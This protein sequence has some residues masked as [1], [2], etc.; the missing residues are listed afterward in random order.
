MMFFLTT[1]IGED[2]DYWLLDDE[3][4][5]YFICAKL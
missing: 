5:F 4:I 3:W 1:F 2:I